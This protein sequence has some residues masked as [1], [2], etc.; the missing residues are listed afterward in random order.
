MAIIPMGGESTITIQTVSTWAITL[1]VNCM[2]L[3]SEYL[4]Q[5]KLNTLNTQTGCNPM[6]I[7][8]ILTMTDFMAHLTRIVKEQARVDSIG[9]MGIG[10]MLIT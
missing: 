6:Q 9:Q 3:E 1:E 7:L 5:D 4:T 10:M 8:L 2:D